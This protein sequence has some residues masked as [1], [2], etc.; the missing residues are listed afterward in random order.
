MLGFCPLARETVLFGD[1]SEG[2]FLN[3]ISLFNNEAWTAL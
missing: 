2:A 3:D 1:A